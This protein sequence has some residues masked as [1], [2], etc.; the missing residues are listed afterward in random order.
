MSKQHTDQL[1]AAQRAAYF[2]HGE[3]KKPAVSV[4][5]GAHTFTVEY[6]VVNRKCYD[7]MPTSTVGF[8]VDGKRTSR[9]AAYKL[10]EAL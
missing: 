1:R 2:E 3:T 5:L 6:I 9:A 8:K 10:A 4:E 7:F